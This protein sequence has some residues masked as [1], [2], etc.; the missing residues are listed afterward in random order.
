MSKTDRSREQLLQEI[1]ALH[2]RNQELE[3]AHARYQ[4]VTQLRHRQRLLFAPQGDAIVGQVP[5][6]FG[7]VI[8]DVEQQGIVRLQ[9]L[10]RLREP[11]LQSGA[12]GRQQREAVDDRVCI[13]DLRAQGACEACPL[14]QLEIGLR[15]LRAAGDVGFRV[16]ASR[17]EDDNVACRNAGV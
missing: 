2:R 3:A 9:V 10:S 6:V 5:G 14:Q 13:A 17:V 16:V 4:Q 1:A 7:A 11:R 8:G 12:G 15:L